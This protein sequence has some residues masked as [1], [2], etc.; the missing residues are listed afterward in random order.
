MFIDGKKMEFDKETTSV[1]EIVRS[2]GIRMPTLCDH[3]ELE[4]YGGCRMCLVEI[5]GWKGFVTACT[6]RP[7]DGMVVKTDSEELTK[8]KRNIL[9]L[10]I[11]E[12]PSACLVCFEWPDCLKYRHQSYRAGAVTGCNT[13][14]N[15]ETCELRE[16]VEHL[17][18]EDLDYDPHYKTVPVE[19]SDPFFDRDYNLCILCARCVRVCDE[20]RGTGAI[21]FSQR[22]HETRVDTAFGASHIDSGCWFCGACIDVCPT[23][24]LMPRM[25]KWTGT[26]DSEVETTC[27]LC[28]MGCQTRL[29]VKWERVMGSGPGST[30]KP[31]SHGHMCVLGRF[32]IPPMVNASDRIKTPIL[33]KEGEYVPVSWDEALDEVSKT[34]IEADAERAGFLGGPHMSSES[35]YLFNKL[36][37]TGIK[38]ANVD[39]QGSDFAALIHKELAREQDFARIRTLGYLQEVDWIISIGGDF[40]ET[41]QAVAKQVYDVVRNGVPLIVVD[42]VGTNLH[43]WAT[44]HVNLPPKKVQPVLSQLAEHKTRLRGV[45]GKQAERIVSITKNGKGAVLVG[46]RILESKEPGLALRTLV[47]LAGADGAI[48]PLFP[49]GNEA[50]V[51]KAGLR[52]ELL[53]GPS[54]VTVKKTRSSVKKAW[55]NGNFADGLNL[56]EMRQ[57]A[58]KKQLDVLYIADGSI[59]LEG[60]EKV[61]TIIYQS[62]YPSEWM[63]VASVILPS[64]TFVEE[65]GTFVNL[66]MRPLK[67]KRVVQAPG[68]A[69][70]DWRIFADIG[71][72]MGTDGFGYSE[73]EEVW[74][75]LLRFA[76]SIEVG[77][78]SRRP[79]WK[80]ASREKSEWYP[81]YRGAA[82]PERI[83]DLAI[84]ME[85]LP[86][87]DRPV[88]EETLNELVKRL[89]GERASQS[90]EV[91]G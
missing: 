5:E 85:A 69:R 64:T 82:L 56:T 87:R 4:P 19:R 38:S 73:A 58:K 10:I 79:S 55:G 68:T 65:N 13:C 17:D 91:S 49:R 18:I 63:D 30:N 6:T 74:D 35:A 25:T 7:Q 75:E 34:L 57:K 8:M 15:R 61:P 42:E 3:P 29:D 71:R 51:I 2:A 76:R 77:G 21:T 67:M 46:Q 48:Y 66:E 40:V 39:F 11:K 60:F 88:S 26:P 23:G 43:R 12:H 44:E 24:A 27:V 90:E 16:V 28:G 53:P 36:S 78:Q 59:S 9:Q 41:H 32:C 37:R 86:E 54:S 31:P 14:P 70:E 84:F 50:G 80:P 22:G 47:R 81:R 83:Q 52:P 20:V 45:D 1:L 33:R 89:E 62:P 72:R